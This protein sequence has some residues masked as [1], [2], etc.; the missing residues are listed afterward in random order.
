MQAKLLL[1]LQQKVAITSENVLWVNGRLRRNGF[2]LLPECLNTFS[3]FPLSS[4]AHFRG[5]KLAVFMAGSPHIQYTE[6]PSIQHYNT[7][8]KLLFS[9]VSSGRWV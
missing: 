8:Q 6:E 3:S 5:L 1:D 2:F 7:E 9:I 4:E